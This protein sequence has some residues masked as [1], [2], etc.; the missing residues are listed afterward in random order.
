[1]GNRNK[2]QI[3]GVRRRLSTGQIAEL[4]TSTDR[5]VAKLGIPTE[6]EPEPSGQ[7]GDSG[8][9]L[10]EVIGGFTLIAMSALLNYQFY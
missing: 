4:E 8:F 9:G 6:P 1:M 3:R 7:A 5:L 10:V 2:P